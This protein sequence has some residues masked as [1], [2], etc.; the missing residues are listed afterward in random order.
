MPVVS[1]KLVYLEL[2]KTASTFIQAVLVDLFGAHSTV[3]HGRLLEEDRSKFVIGSVRN[4]WDYYVSLW[5]FGC[6]G[7]GAMRKRA[8]TRRFGVA[9][10]E[11]P[12][13][14]PLLRELTKPTR[15]WRRHYEAPH[16]PE[17][18]N[19]WLVDMHTP[20]RA[21][22]IDPYYGSSAMR[23]VAGYATYRYCN[24]YT[25]DVAAVLA[26]NTEQTLRSAVAENYL[27]NAVIRFEHLVDDLIETTRAAGYVVD[28]NLEEAVRQRAGTPVNSSTHKPYWEYYD[29]R[30]REIV[31]RRDAVIVERHGYRFG[32]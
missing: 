4:P 26:S 19:Q 28:E 14:G 1:D 5:S 30:S 2:P 13:V 17:K 27:P 23:G 24:L 6:Q 21:P 29:E 9:R 32:S 20:A 12:D 11:L 8:T 10:R 7:N 3:R 31:G 25:D 18:F 22:Q 15:R 16:T